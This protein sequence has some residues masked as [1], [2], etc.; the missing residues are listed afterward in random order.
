MLLAIKPTD[1][2]IVKA[3]I[4]L[5]K[6]AREEYRDSWKCYEEFQSSFHFQWKL[7]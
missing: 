6:K 2:G 3:A 1:Y 4:T 7:D 5:G